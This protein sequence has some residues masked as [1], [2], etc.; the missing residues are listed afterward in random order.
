MDLDERTWLLVKTT[1]GVTRFIGSGKKPSALTADEV[2]N[3]LKRSRDAEVKPS[4]KI[5]FESQEA[6]RVID[7]PFVNFN[8]VIE[9]V[10]QD[11]QKIKVSVSIFG[12]STPLELEFWQV[13]KV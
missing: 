12:R 2:D 9:E 4:S 11:K 5:S 6:V 13:E 1:P 7:G 3:I 8:G 10:H